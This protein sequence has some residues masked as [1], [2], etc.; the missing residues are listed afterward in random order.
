MPFKFYSLFFQF[1][2][3]KWPENWECFESSLHFL[4]V[5]AQWWSLFSLSR[6]SRGWSAQ[7][8]MSKSGQYDEVP[9]SLAMSS[10]SLDVTLHLFWPCLVGCALA[11][12]SSPFIYTPGKQPCKADTASFEVLKNFAIH[13]Q[14]QR[15]CNFQASQSEIPT[16][17]V[18]SC[19]FS[20]KSSASILSL[21]LSQSRV[22]AKSTDVLKLSKER[23]DSV[24]SSVD[25]MLCWG[26][27][28]C[29]NA[30][31]I[32]IEKLFVAPY[33]SSVEVT[34]T[35]YIFVNLLIWSGSVNTILLR[36]ST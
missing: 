33:G 27:F 18:C 24:F 13:L 2:L 34:S 32:L 17:V 6:Y 1:A 4:C 16:G 29:R 26:Y 20:K 11:Q 25:L 22:P 23:R 30:A 28:S 21:N 8:I 15:D 19:F 10:C 3:V 7:R 31:F 36:R 9:N 14:D 5:C 12:V 35:Y